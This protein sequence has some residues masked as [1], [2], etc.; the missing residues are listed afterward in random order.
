MSQRLFRKPTIKEVAVKAGVSITTVSHYMQ[1]RHGT[2]STETAQ[3]I[4]Q[5]I[6]DLH[7][8]PNLLSSSLVRKSTQTIGIS[9]AAPSRLLRSFTDDIW[10]GVNLE[11]D[12]REYSLL[13]YPRATRNADDY[14]VFLDGRIDGL[15]LSAAHGDPRPERLAAAGLPTVLLTRSQD[16]PSDCGGVFANESDTV[17][18]ALSHLWALGHRRIAH[19]AGPTMIDPDVSRSLSTRGYTDS[20]VWR[21][22]AFVG[23][24]AAHGV[25]DHLVSQ[26]NWGWSAVNVDETLVEWMN[27]NQRPTALF[28][29]NDVLAVAAMEC[30]VRLGLNVPRDLSIVGVDNAVDSALSTVPL[31]TVDID[32]ALIGQEAVRCLLR[33]MEGDS[34]GPRIVTVPVT[35]LVIRDSTA[36]P[37]P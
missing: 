19:I 29:A 14:R 32:G 22:E 6:D 28:C 36:P 15:I 18:L 31:T 1:G 35:N 27:L 4:K 17:D 5:V 11:S 12:E 2:C 33:L 20:A 10:R 26:P 8:T 37:S 13:H 7:Y 30:A 3:R 21:S 25:V 24:L 16:I 9:L 23:W 34:S